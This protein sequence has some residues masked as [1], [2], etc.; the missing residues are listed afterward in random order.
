MCRDHAHRSRRDAGNLLAPDRRRNAA[1]QQVRRACIRPPRTAQRRGNVR[2]IVHA[3]TRATHL[4]SS[5]SSP[6][7]PLSRPCQRRESGDRIPVASGAARAQLLLDERTRQLR[8][9]DAVRVHDVRFA[10]VHL[11][12]FAS[13]DRAAQRRNG[14]GRRRFLQKH[15]EQMTRIGGRFLRERIRGNECLPFG[16]GAHKK[17][18]GQAEALLR[19]SFEQ[20][21]EPRGRARTS[22]DDISALQ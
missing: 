17:R 18:S 11:D 14:R 3:F 2:L 20:P 12:G 8:P 9:A 22:K 15:D 6:S 5:P 10:S 21:L 7:R 1:H 4:R 19:R 13:F 16:R